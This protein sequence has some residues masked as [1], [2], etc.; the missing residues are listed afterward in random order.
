MRSWNDWVFLILRNILLYVA[1]LTGSAIV[2]MPLFWMLL[3]AFKEPGT[4]LKNQFLPETT[5]VTGVT[6]LAPNETAGAFQSYT[7]FHT[8]PGAKR[9]TVAGS[10]NGWNAAASEMKTEGGGVFQT[11]LRLP[12]GKHEYK[13]VVD[14]KWLDGPNQALEIAASPDQS[15]YD[16]KTVSFL[17]QAATATA[18]KVQTGQA[19]IPLQKNSDGVWSG[20]MEN[21]QAAGESDSAVS[22]RFSVH[23]SFLAGL[24]SIYTFANFKLIRNSPDFPFG[25]FFL[26]SLV[27]ASA[28]G[29][30][31]VVLCTLAGYV[32]AVKEFTGKDKLFYVLLSVMMVPGMIFFVPQF[33]LVNVIGKM[34]FFGTTLQELR[35]FGVNTY[36]GMIVPHLANVFGIFL[37]RQYIETIPH[38]LF[39]AARMDGANE[40]HELTKIVVPLAMPIMVTLFLLTFLGQW[41]NFLWQLV[42]NT[43]DSPLRTLPVG[44]ALFRGQYAIQWELMM[45]GA[46]FSIVPV[47]VLF[48]MAQRYFI[49]GMTQGAVKG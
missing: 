8:S 41:T 38:S 10:F 31:T 1:L 24:K 18:V 26:N 44:L 49:E 34:P 22:Y 3:T 35:I 16:G 37:M 23:T 43:P 17:Y 9:V 27:V 4:A 45:A 47:A 32:F 14:G 42:V 36:A 46:C 25:R 29:L 20:R 48:V 2:L 33:A 15:R 39:E 19:E 12:P 11:T 13:F 40:Y 7:F 5:R 30:L 6:V 21:A 28:S